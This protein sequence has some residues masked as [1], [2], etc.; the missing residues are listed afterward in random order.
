MKFAVRLLA[1]LPTA[2]WYFLSTY[3]L[4][5]LLYSI[6]SYRK[7]VVLQNMRN[8]F[9]EKSEA[10]I[11][12][13]SKKFYLYLSDLFVE[14]LR[15]F[16]IPEAEL[17]KSVSFENV[18]IVEKLYQEHKNVILT[19]GHMGNY[20]WMAQA[21]HFG[22]PHA[23][24][25]A[26]RK[27]K[28]ALIEDLLKSSRSRYGVELFPTEDTGVFLKKRK[29]RPFM[30]ALANDQSAHPHKCFW[31]PFLNQATSF[32]VGTEK[33]SQ[34]INAPVVFAYVYRPHRGKYTMR[35]ELISENPK[36][37]AEGKIMKDHA[38][39]LE[40]NI[41]EQPEIWLWSHKRWKHSMPAE[42]SFGFTPRNQS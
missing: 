39:F 18:E 10:E 4:Y 34:K 37:E 17:R 33:V 38:A 21:F 3:F 31:T 20:E 5:P 12:N 36:E 7:K 40:K 11:K 42:Y 8:A 22:L 6:L 35:F 29:E 23:C 26:Y 27:Q 13:L 41:L 15:S 19:L 30:L 9:P 14:T 2:F 1:S 25:V 24:A 32:Y 16:S 28:N